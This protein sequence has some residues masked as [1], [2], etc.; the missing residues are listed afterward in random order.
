M[1]FGA[2]HRLMTNVLAVLGL[3][4][5]VTSSTLSNP[6]N[7]AIMFGAAI[8]IAIPETWQQK[9]L[10]RESATFGPLALIALEGIRLFLGQS[11]IDVAVEFAAFLQVF[12]LATRRGAAHDQQIILLALLHFIV[13]TVLGGGI[14]FGLCFLGFLMVAPGALV[15]SHLRREV[16]GNYRQGARDRTGLPVDVPRILR[17]RRVV[18]RNFLLATGLLSVPILVFTALLFML[19]PRVGLSLLVINHQKNGRMVGFSD[20]VD[21]GDVGALRAD[22]SIALRFTLAEMPDPPP[23]KMTLRLRGTGFD[24]YDGRAWLRT[25][26]ERKN[27]EATFGGSEYPIVRRSRATDKIIRFELEPLEPPVIFIPV[28][29][30]GFVVRSPKDQGMLGQGVKVLAGPEGEFRHNGNQ[31]RGLQYDAYMPDTRDAIPLMPMPAAD[32]MRYLQRPADLPPRIADLAASWTAG[33]T[34]VRKKIEI[35]QRRLQTEYGYDLGSPSGG[36]PQPVDHFLFTSRKGHC[37]FFSTS[38]VM[39]LRSVGIPSRNV[40]GFVG[41][42]YNRFGKYYSVREGEAHSWVEAFVEEGPTGPQG[43][44]QGSWITVDPT[45]PSGS[46]PMAQ[47]AG[48]WVYMRDLFE[49]MSQRWSRHVVGYDIY[50]QMRLLESARSKLRGGNTTDSTLKA[51]ASRFPK[52][53]R[54]LLLVGVAGA[55]ALYLYR[56]NK[57]RPKQ[58]PKGKKTAA[59]ISE[60]RLV[61][62]YKNLET[63]LQQKGI[64]RP[65]ATTPLRFAEG[66]KTSAH[67]LAPKVVS[68]TEVYLGARFGTQPFDGSD[69]QAFEIEIQ[70][71]KAWS[72]EKPV[73]PA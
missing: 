38:M 36:T 12:R 19:F 6:I 17:S 56:K 54:W 39:L 18:G 15:L 45:P 43:G 66:L 60:A 37:E 5:V 23:E 61:A 34:S 4:A 8:A 58:E 10:V 67:P 25:Q 71:I 63:A 13:G 26:A 9:T 40:T 59:S 55:A 72:P 32:R 24:A 50:Q 3:L 48:A 22:P 29:A 51:F 20:R 30:A 1:R 16:E 46:Q 49:A 70:N 52:S 73:S 33:E 35:I 7:L 28:Q 68:L 64:T 42:T 41:G 14:A 27:I 57:L 44:S 31:G 69:I 53:F 65:A 11:P 47:T 21:L 2:V 62:L